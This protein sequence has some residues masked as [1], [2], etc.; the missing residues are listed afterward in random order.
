MSKPQKQV[1]GVL[2]VILFLDL[3]ISQRFTALWKHA[4]SSSASQ[5]NQQKSS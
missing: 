3:A 2:L 1:L 4:F 5:P